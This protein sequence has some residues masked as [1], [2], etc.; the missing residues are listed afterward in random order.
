MADDDNDTDPPVG[1]I[2]IDENTPTNP[3]ESVKRYVTVARRGNVSTPQQDYPGEVSTS[4]QFGLLCKLWSWT[5][6]IDS[7]GT[8]GKPIKYFNC[9]MDQTRLIP[10]RWN[11]QKPL[12]DNVLVGPYLEQIHVRMG[13]SDPRAIL[14][15]SQPDTDRIGGSISS[16]ISRSFSGGFFGYIPTASVSGTVSHSSTV[17]MRDFAVTNN[18]LQHHSDHIVRLSMLIGPQAG[19]YKDWSSVQTGGWSWNASNDSLPALATSDVPLNMQ[20]LWELPG[21]SNDV[22]DFEVLVDCTFVMLPNCREGWAITS[23]ATRSPPSEV[24]Q[25]AQN[26]WGDPDTVL[27]VKTE[28]DCQWSRVISVPLKNADPR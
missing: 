18:S 26:R 27:D 17:S 11:P 6:I 4:F 12:P 22:L 21:D 7:A 24:A 10:A 5:P 23:P 20:G 8:K 2:W 16:S 1:K 25:Q 15:E 19:P 13:F 28:F 14:A 3:P 9:A